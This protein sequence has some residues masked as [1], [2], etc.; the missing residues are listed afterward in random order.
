MEKE[1]RKEVSLLVSFRR[2][3]EYV[4]VDEIIKLTARKFI[5]CNRHKTGQHC[6]SEELH[7]FEPPALAAVLQE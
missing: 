6:L 7:E 5:A 4:C 2:E 1:G 3:L